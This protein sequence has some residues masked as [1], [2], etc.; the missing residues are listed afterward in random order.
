MLFVLWYYSR[1]YSWLWNQNKFSKLLL[2]YK[3]LWNPLWII[4]E[5]MLVNCTP[6]S[7]TG[8]V[9]CRVYLRFSK[10]C[11]WGDCGLIYCHRDLQ[12]ITREP[13][14]W[15]NYLRVPRWYI[16]PQSPQNVIFWPMVYVYWWGNNVRISPNPVN[17]II[18]HMSSIGRRQKLNSIYAL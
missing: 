13:K 4:S 9:I 16:R 6:H 10:Y 5:Q 1:V 15:G 3:C 8:N 12:I 11:I 14:V 7:I 2:R 17:L 18:L